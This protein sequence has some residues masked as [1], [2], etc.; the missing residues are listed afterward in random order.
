MYVPLNVGQPVGRLAYLLADSGVGVVVTTRDLVGGLVGFE[1]GVVLVDEV[2]WSVGGAVAEVAV[3]GEGLAYV[4]YTSGS[5]GRPKGVAV[6]HRGLAGYVAG[7]Q[8]A[9]E[10]LGGP[11]VTLSMTSPGFDVSVGDMVRALCAGRAVVF[12]PQ[13]DGVSVEELHAVLLA[14]RVEI[15]DIVPG[16]LLR[17]LAAYCRHAGA[18]DALRLVISGTVW[19]YEALMECVKAVAPGA[20]PAN[21]YGVTEAAIDSLMMSLGEGDTGSMVPVGRPLAGVRVY[22]VDEWLNVVPVG[23]P[24]E[25]FIGGV[26]VA[27]GYVGRADLTAERFVAD[28]FV[29]GGGRLYRTGDRVRWRGDGVLEFLGR[30]DD[31]VKIRGFR[32]E[33]GEVEVVLAGHPEVRDAVVVARED[34]PSGVR[35]VGYVVAAEGG[36]LESG[37]LRG[38]LRE[39]LPEFMVPAAFVV[40]DVLPLT[41]NGKVDRRALPDPGVSVAGVEYVP[42]R[43]RVE[44][45]LAE[46]WSQVL[47]VERVGVRDN[48]FDLGGDSILSLQI[49]ARARA[50]GLR[51]EVADVFARQSVAELAG[52][53]GDEGVVSGV[54]PL[55]V[56]QCGLLE[57]GAGRDGWCRWGVFELA[58]GVDVGVLG[59]A[60]EALVARHDVLRA[61]VLFEEGRGWVQRVVG[62]ESA[63]V[64]SVVEAVGVEEGMA[65]VR[66]SVSVVDGPVLR[67]VL[68]ERGDEPCLLGVVVH[69]LVVDA[70]SW[71]VLL[72]DLSGLCGVA[73]SEKLVDGL[74]VD[75]VVRVRLGVEDSAAVLVGVHG[76]YRTVV[77]DVLAA[78]L[79]QGVGGQVAV[80]VDG[81]GVDLSGRVGWFCSFVAVGVSGVASGDA[82]VVLKSVKEQ[83]RGGG[84]VGDV[85]VLVGWFGGEGVGLP[86]RLFGLEVRGWRAGDGRVE[87]EWHFDPGLYRAESVQGMADA[88][89]R[90]L[91]GLIAHCLSPGAGGFTPSDFPLAGLDQ[92]G[93]DRLVAGAAVADVYRL[94]PVQL[95]MLFHTLEAPAEVSG[96]YLA[97]ELR[98]VS[99]RLDVAALRRAWDVVVGRHAALRTGFVW[100]GVPEPVQVVHDA[101]QVPFEVLDWSH[102][103]TV[104]V[105]SRIEELLAADRERPFDIS[106]P[107]LMRVCVIDRGGDRHWTLWTFHHI[108]LD[109]W[110]VPIVLDEVLQTYEALKQEHQL[111]LPDAPCYRDFVA[112]LA[113]RDAVEAEEFWR[114]YLAGFEAATPLPVD[115]QATRQWTHDSRRLELSREVTTGLLELAR[116]ARVTPGTVIQAGWALLLSRYSGERDV[117]FGLTVSGRP[118]ELPGVESMVGMFINTLPVRARV[119]ADV[120]FID[121][122]RELQDNQIAL[123][124][125]E[126]TSLTDIQKLSMVPHGT[127]LFDS[128]MVFGNYPEGELPEGDDRPGDNEALFAPSDLAERGHYPLTFAV[129]LRDRLE[130]KVEFS[131]AAFD[132]ATVDRLLGQLGVVFS[133]VV[134]DVGVL[135]R[136]VG[137]VSGG[138]RGD[139][140]G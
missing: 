25:L 61:R 105:H 115:R 72:E 56:A 124:R 16:T 91:R 12:L 76:A 99:G 82:G 54:V 40:V 107:P 43:T 2:D 3:E 112:W 92:V 71:G 89:V 20:T 103:D 104:S 96:V 78:A 31:Q 69:G 77:G 86:E 138:G 81:V 114:S 97:Q 8:R 19:N 132:G 123:Q 5:T 33:P 15:A 67:V 50:A 90:A 28:P 23:V 80:Q 108:C 36:Q 101:V 119:P 68:F 113:E 131:A 121:W 59:R 84:W 65:A 55:T 117:V 122:L 110:S 94:T 48:F 60:V 4:A 74:G 85:E 39:R 13:A 14:H 137:L 133:V 11:G 34:G 30:V 42:P 93:V 135:V 9:L 24:G 139:L 116:Q 136:D 1:G 52:V 49:V 18:L 87:L 46:I 106:A 127:S 100:E 37:G 22:V 73:L 98:E 66:G 51:V 62:R 26:G 134:G 64:F 95:G 102:L 79:V 38:F 29:G 63:G 120:P 140:V 57:R 70:R 10:G 83:V 32:V 126:H 27:R 17:D 58:A 7:W 47:G 6:T 111:E 128:I 75:G 118:V 109:G 125:F 88:H 21:A 129:E 45:V 35:L 130:I 44:V 41:A 53:V